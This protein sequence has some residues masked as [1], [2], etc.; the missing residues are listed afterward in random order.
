MGTALLEVQGQ[1]D[2]ASV[3]PYAPEES[4]L[5]AADLGESP[6]K[7]ALLHT[8]HCRGPEHPHTLLCLIN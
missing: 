6:G 3:P 5:I 4:A 1:K 7:N 2:Q 8:Y